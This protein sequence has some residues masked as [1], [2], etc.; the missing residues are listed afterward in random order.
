L[1]DVLI[2]I[3][4]SYG[5]KRRDAV[6]LILENNIYGLDIDE[7]ARQL[8]YFSLMM[9]AREYD[10]RFLTRDYIPQPKV[11]VVEESNYFKKEIGRY[12]LEYFIDGDKSLKEAIES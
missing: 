11:Y 10:R 9:K 8:A 6:R 1:F 4:E 7:R 3:Y 2:E 12:A 5:Y